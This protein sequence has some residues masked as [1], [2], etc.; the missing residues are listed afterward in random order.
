[1]TDRNAVNYSKL[2]RP[3]TKVVLFGE[4]IHNTIAFKREFITALRA[5]KRRN[6]THVALE[7]FP[8][9]L[10]DKLEAYSRNGQYESVLIQHLQEFWGYVPKAKQYIDIMKTARQ[11]NMTIIGI[12]MPYKDFDKH[13]CKEKNFD[14]CKISTHGERNK[15]M[16]ERIIEHTKKGAKIVSFMQY[17]H[18][19]SRNRSYETGIKK[20]LRAKGLSPIFISLVGGSDGA[21]FPTAIA[22]KNE[23][24]GQTRFVVKGRGTADREDYI[25]HL[26]Q[27]H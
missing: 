9:D 26:P 21:A 27:S 8:A 15:Y 14:N 4:T 11:L 20:L 5:L 17:W 18:A 23:N 7:M 1:M 6:F 24:L 25:V 10:N 19:R 22:A 13:S 3:N 12:D 2:I 16:V